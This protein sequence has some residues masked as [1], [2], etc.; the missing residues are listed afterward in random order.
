[1]TTSINL[2]DDFDSEIEHDAGKMPGRWTNVVLLSFAGLVD[3][4]EGGILGILFTVMRPALGLATSALGFIAALG[5]LV[6]AIFG[7]LWG[8]AGDRYNRKSILVFATGVW[9]IWTIALGMVN[10][11]TQVLILVAISAAGASATTPVTNSVLSDLFT[12]K[13]RGWAKGVW[14]GITG[15]LGI[16]AIV[17]VGQLENVPD[18]WRMGYYAAGGLSVLSGILIYFFYK[19]PVR[20]QTDAGM[21]AVAQKAAAAH[22]FSFDKVKTLF[23]NRSL[24]LMLVDKFLIGTVTLFTFLPTFL[25]DHR[26]IPV[27]EGS[28]VVGALAGGLG[29]GRFIAGALSTR[30]GDG[31]SRINARSI[32]Y[33]VALTLSFVFLV[34]SLAVDFGTDIGPYAIVNL[35]LGFVL[36]FDNP[37]MHPM[38]ARITTPELRSTAYGLWQSGS[39]RLGDVLFTLLVG[40]L[41]ASMGLDNVLLYMVSGLVLIRIVIWF[42][43]YRTYSD[44]VAY[45][46]MILAERLAELE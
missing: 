21:G 38:I 35:L 27:A 16:I 10:S 46:D 12:D 37:I 17:M 13:T 4:V 5:K 14:A 15:I 39:E 18:G 33:H 8:M 30:I 7:P 25:A 23:K 42:V 29:I 22:E 43:I 36:A 24:K 32:I 3:G 44:D 19:E 1:M 41:T 11:Y 6:G 20:G 45:N 34:I 2:D 31:S 9:G 28:L 26:G 40:L